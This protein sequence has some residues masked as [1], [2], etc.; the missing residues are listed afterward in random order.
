MMTAVLQ[1]VG[2]VTL[3]MVLEMMRVLIYIDIGCEATR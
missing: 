1:R 2:G 3:S